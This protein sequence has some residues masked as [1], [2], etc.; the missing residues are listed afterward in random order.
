MDYGIQWAHGDGGG[1]LFDELPGGG[2][3]LFGEC[4]CL[5]CENCDPPLDG[6]YTVTLSNIY[7]PGT[8]VLSDY[9]GAWD[10][11]FLSGCIWYGEFDVYGT[12]DLQITMEW[13]DDSP[14]DN[15]SHWFVKAEML[16]DGCSITW[17][18]VINTALPYP[19]CV[20]PPPGALYILNL[21]EGVCF[22]HPL[23]VRTCVVS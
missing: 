12:S 4:C 21:Y 15:V 7:T 14:G 16:N 1:P 13:R 22:P 10:I 20:S 3:A 8:A 19:Y 2:I 6:T 17:R 11:D 5:T 18:K 23:V 9:N